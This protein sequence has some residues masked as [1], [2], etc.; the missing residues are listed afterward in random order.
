MTPPHADF[1]HGTG[2]GAGTFV[3]PARLTATTDA[4]RSLYAQP[5]PRTD[6]EHFLQQIC[7]HAVDIVDGAH[8]AGITIAE[9]DSTH[10][11]VAATDE[12]VHTV[13]ELQFRLGAGPA[14]ESANTSGVVHAHSAEASRRWPQ[15]AGEAHHAGVSSFLSAPLPGQGQPLGTLNLY[16]RDQRGFTDADAAVIEL[17]ALTAY[18]AL[19]SSHRLE[20]ARARTRDL[21]LALESRGVIEQAKGIIMGTRHVTADDAFAMLI[22]ES[23]TSNIKLRIVAQQHI[24]AAIHPGQTNADSHDTRPS[25]N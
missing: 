25:T 6:A 3:L 5:D 23:Q 12:R 11:T 16:S 19:L 1:C 18:F 2:Y 20:L 21:E 10:R 14:V 4:L 7:N 24:A 22:Q 8:M 13:D 9:S 15:F 17:F